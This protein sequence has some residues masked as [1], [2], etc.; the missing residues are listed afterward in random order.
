[1]LI[2]VGT[3]TLAAQNSPRVAML[4]QSGWAAIKAGNFPAA[5]EAFREVIAIEPKNAQAHAM[6]ALIYNLRGHYDEAEQAARAAIGADSKAPLGQAMLA[7]ALS[8]QSDYTEALTAAT[9]RALD[10]QERE[11]FTRIQHAAQRAT[12]LGDGV[13]HPTFPAPQNTWRVTKCGVT[14]A[15][16]RPNGVSRA[17]R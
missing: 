9:G 3:S 10:D 11:E 7:E 6:L 2:L 5:Q 1:M 12:Y 14:W 17:R 4:E 13:S 16:I 8:G 15:T